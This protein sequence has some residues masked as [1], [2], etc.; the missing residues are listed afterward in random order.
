MVAYSYSCSH[1]YSHAPPDQ[2]FRLDRYCTIHTFGIAY[3][4]FMNT[5]HSIQAV[6]FDFDGV[7]ADTEPLHHQAF[8]QVAGRDGLNCTWEEYVRDYVGYDDR[9]LFR[10]AY[11]K[12]GRALSDADTRACVEAKAQAFIALTA[13]GVQPYEGIPDLILYAHEHYPIGL[14][15]GALRSDIAPILKQLKLTDVFK[16]IVTAEDVP[17]SKPDPA[18][19]R[20]A[21]ERLGGVIGRALAPGDCVAIEDTPGGI[22]AAK[23]AGLRVWAVTHTHDPEAV[24]HADEVFETLPDITSRLNMSHED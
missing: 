10:A 22:R 9:D 23:G 3:N 6:I 17:A 20:L 8:C 2:G 7:I 13:G 11:Q 12:A 15:S 1:C 24:A 19:Y 16:V 21:V 4:R 14:C 5:P 18:C